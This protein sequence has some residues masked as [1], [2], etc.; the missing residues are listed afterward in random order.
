MC[1]AL[2]VGKTREMKKRLKRLVKEFKGMRRGGYDRE[3]VEL[4]LGF[5]NYYDISEALCV[6]FAKVGG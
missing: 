4:A 2:G 3:R 1:K 5:K 6:P